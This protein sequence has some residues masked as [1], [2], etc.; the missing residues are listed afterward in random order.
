MRV[1]NVVTTSDAP[2]FE[3]QVEVL[4]EKGVESDTVAVSQEVSD[5]ASSD[6]SRSVRDYAR[7]VVSL[8]RRSQHEYDL[9]H[10]HY[11][12]LSPLAFVEL[13]RPV[14]VTFWGSDLMAG[15]WFSHVSQAMATHCDEVIVPSPAM[16]SYLSCPHHVIPFG[17]DVERFRPVDP[18]AFLAR[19]GLDDLP[20]DRP[21]VGYTGRHGHEKRLEAVVEA[22]ADLDVT[23]VFAG[24]GPARSKLEKLAVAGDVDGRFLGCLDREELPAFYSALDVFAFP[25]PVETQGIVAMEAMASGT[26]VVAAAAGALTETVEDGVTGYHFEPGDVAGFRD[27]IRRAIEERDRLREAC[28]D[29]REAM[30]VDH[31]VDRLAEVYASLTR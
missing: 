10:I 31:A 6:A 1:L 16:S 19:H 24:D 7:T 11:G 30:S 25:S 12:L 17:V 28:L 26:P 2:F 8:L 20:A 4:A 27:A 9:I 29:R 13:T 18:S 22:A 23:V 14:V 21:L 15:D 5:T 3:Q